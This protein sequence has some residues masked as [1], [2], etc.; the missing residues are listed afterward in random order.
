[1]KNITTFFAVAL[2]VFATQLSQAAII[3]VDADATGLNNGNTWAN[4]YEDLQDAL[5]VAVSGDEIWVA[6]GIYK[7][8]STNDRSISFEI[9]DGVD[10]YGGFNGTEPI[11]SQRD[12][13]LNLSILSGAIGAA[14]DNTDNTIVIVDIANASTGVVLDGFHIRKAYLGSSEFGGGSAIH[15]TQSTASILHCSIYEND[16]RS[17][18]ALYL[19]EA[20]VVLDNCLIRDNHSSG[21]LTFQSMT[22][23]IACSYTSSLSIV[24]CSITGNTH[25]GPDQYIID[26]G[27]A[28]SSIDIHNSILWDNEGGNIYTVS[29]TNLSNSIVQGGYA[30]TDILDSDPLFTDPAGSDFT[31]QFVSPA[32]N[33]GDN[34]YN[35]VNLDLAHLTRQFDGS[36]DMGCYENHVPAIIYV[37]DSAS[38]LNDGTSWANAFEDLQDALAAATDGYEIWVDDGTYKPTS[39][40]DRTIKFTIPEGVE[41][42]GGFGGFEALRNQRDWDLFPAI[43]SGAIGGVGETDNSRQIIYSSTSEGIVIDGFDIRK[44]YNEVITGG[45]IILSNGNPIIKH[46][47]IHDNYALGGSAFVGGSME[48]ITFEECLFYDNTTDNDKVIRTG[49]ANTEFIFINCTMTRNETNGSYI[50]GGAA[51]PTFTF[52]NCILWNHDDPLFQASY[53]INLYS[54]IVEDFVAGD[55][56]D[57]NNVISLNP[58]FTDAA[59]DDFTIKLESPAHNAGDNALSNSNLDLAANARIYEDIVDIGCYENPTPSI[60]FVDQD[61]SGLNNGTT[62]TDAYT[63]LHEALNNAI[64]GQ[65]IWV[66][67]GTYFSSSFNNR[68]E[69]FVLKNNIPV[70]GG[71]AGGETSLEERDWFNNVSDLSGNI[72]SQFL[73]TDNAYHVLFANDATG[74]FLIDGFSIH[75]GYANGAG[76]HED[77][78]GAALIEYSTGTFTMNNCLVFNNYTEYVGG[79]VSTFAN[80]VFNNT[81]FLAN[82]SH[83]GGA[84]SWSYGTTME[85][86]LF[87][88]NIANIG[89]VDHNTEGTMDMRGCTFEGNTVNWQFHSMIEGASGVIANTVIWGNTSALVNQ[90]AIQGIDLDVH[91]CILQGNALNATIEGT[92]VYY[93]NPHYT[94]ATN[95]D[96]ALQ[97]TSVGINTGDNSLVTLANDVVGNP[98]ILFGTVDMGAVESYGAV[99]GIIYVDNDAT[100]NNDGS[101]WIDAFTSLQSALIIAGVGAEIWVAEGIYKPTPEN[102]RWTYFEMV[103]SLSMYG[104]FSGV[105]LHRSELNWNTFPTI[106]SGEI[107]AATNSDNS[108]VLLNL[109]DDQGVLVEGFH[110]TEIYGNTEVSEV[111]TAIFLNNNATGIFSHC[112]I[113]GNANYRIPAMNA[114]SGV[115]ELENCLITDNTVTAG[116]IIGS[117]SS[118]GDFSLNSCTLAGNHMLEAVASTLS[119]FVSSEISVVNT[120]IWHNDNPQIATSPT[121]EFANCIIEDFVLGPFGTLVGPVVDIDPQFTNTALDDY[122]LLPSSI[123]VNTGNNSYSYSSRDLDANFRVQNGTIDIGCYESS[124]C[125]QPNDVCDDA[126]ELLVDAQPLMGSTKCA[127]G[128]DSPS[129]AC[130]AVTGKTVWY[131]FDAPASG[132]VIVNADFILNVSTNFNL[133]LSLYSGTCTALTHVACVNATGSGGDEML[134]VTSLTSGNTY[135]LRVDAPA[136]HEGLFMIDVDEVPADCPGDFDDNGAVNV[137]DLL[138][139]NGAF[140]C[141]SSCGEPDLDGNG[142]VNVGDL[143]L[144][145]SLFG[146]VCP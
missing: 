109:D 122:T 56:T 29:S 82:E 35:T 115:G 59:N 23:V 92:E 1:M 125:S 98:R 28:T 18:P 128:G 84:I 107:G 79:A 116:G 72:G 17:N 63:D 143:L 83:I 69:S 31:L 49:S 70:Y 43:L 112:R 89:I 38:G 54:C 119:G 30:G 80:S 141:P 3:L 45:A 21:V 110:L 12:W 108:R 42:Y 86:C 113:Y 144:F 123:G 37:D 71:F 81:I 8:T 106:L 121:I 39:G 15:A 134:D 133:R 6:E 64:E 93:E 145:N 58:K 36:V 103:D 74:S 95:F 7:P 131:S 66:A 73:A 124:D 120:I 60:Y 14:N 50:F 9:P 136:G 13:N 61:A 132:H 87:V 2:L 24:G 19:C 101:N 94:D 90:T 91:H 55:V 20:D 117:G 25:D 138:I 48:P 34:S 32:R 129:N 40:V 78:G 47:K 10:L 5:A 57:Y 139:F 118:L 41:L 142:V 77:I 88:D 76:A 22:I 100:G 51:F 67:N 16:C 53:T 140:G 46:C 4:A 99:P 102:D 114:G 33:Q 68:S 135:Y 126:I 137:G 146:T 85:N 62:W 11:R 52:N 27:S 127:T 96:Y 75:G 111:G 65:Q 130:A 97:S 44:A 105:E 26:C 104:G